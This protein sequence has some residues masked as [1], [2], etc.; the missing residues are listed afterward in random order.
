ML[1]VGL[2]GGIGCGKSAAV[3]RFQSYGVPVVDADLIA[4]QVVAVGEPAL[5]L[6][7]E[8][9]GAEILTSDGALNRAKLR[10]I[11]FS[12]AEQ[13]KRL[14]AILHPL[15]RE[16][17]QQAVESY[18][19]APYVLIDIPLLIEKGYKSL[20]D[21][22]VVVDCLPEQQVARVLQRDQTTEL[23]IQQIMQ[24]QVPREVRLQHATDVLDNTHT[25]EQLYQ[26]VDDLHAKL[27]NI[28]QT[29]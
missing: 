27:L 5:L 2:T 11:V 19:N 7:V 23:L 29:R 1:K 8:A 12:D 28:A 22:V 3:S 9:F 6:L 17:I 4:R 26:A 18:K 15:I 20:C 13:L 14:E 21:R 16:R 25:V 10:Q 24:T